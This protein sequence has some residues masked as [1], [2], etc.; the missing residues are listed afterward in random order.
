MYI[1][2]IYIYIYIYIYI[3]ILI[4]STNLNII[5]ACQKSLV[6]MSPHANVEDIRDC[7]FDPWAGKISWR[8]EWQ[9]MP[10]FMPRE[11][12]DERSLAPTVHR[13]AKNR[14]GLK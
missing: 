9:P 12:L 5:R 14:I 6:V 11:S 1:Y 3:D 2:N 13:V 8:R 10:V 4:R 7:R